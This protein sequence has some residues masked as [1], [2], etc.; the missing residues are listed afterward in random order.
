MTEDGSITRWISGLRRGE[1]EAAEKLWREY[2][3]RM[4]AV[5]GRRLAGAGRRADDEDAA[6]S[7]FKSF[8]V[9]AREGKFPQLR[10][11]DNLWP[12]L[13]ALTSHKCV[14][15]IRRGTRRKRGGG[16]TAVTEELEFITA[17]EPSTEMIAELGER[18]EL[19]LDRLDRTGDP[20]LRRIAIARLEGEGTG[21]IAV[22]LE[23]SRKTIERKLRVIEQVWDRG[24]DDA[25]EPS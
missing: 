16:A 15:E 21:E 18:L 6:L 11:R 2:F 7:A 10:D 25:E 14:D 24:D 17:R 23:C 9:G 3:A 1:D 4:V 8:C 13:L 22:R 19:L 5:A 12:L 20:A